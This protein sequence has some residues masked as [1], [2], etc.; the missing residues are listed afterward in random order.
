MK[1]ESMKQ[2]ESWRDCTNSKVGAC[3]RER[4]MGECVCLREMGWGRNEETSWF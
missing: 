3:N 2:L 1:H 4:E